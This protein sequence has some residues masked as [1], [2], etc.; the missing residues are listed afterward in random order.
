MVM[1][2]AIQE[3]EIAVI[4]AGPG[5]YVAAIRLA[6]LGKQVVLIDKAGL[7]G[8]C[9][10]VGCIPSK[11]LITASN[12]FGMAN[13]K[14]EMG[15]S[16]G[17]V[18]LDSKKLHEWKKASI[19]QLEK[20]IEGLCAKLG[21]EVVKGTATIEDSET[22]R[23][24]SEH[25]T[26][27][28][29]F[30]QCIINTGTTP[31]EY[32]G[33]E[34][35]N[36]FVWNSDHAMDIEFIPRDLVVIGGGYIGVELASVYAKFGCNV[37][38]V[39]RSERI[40]TQMDSDAA[41]VVQKKMS[42]HGIHLFL[43]SVFKSAHRDKNRVSV[44]IESGG[45]K[46]VIETEKILVA[47]GRVPNTKHIGLENTRVQ[48]NEN[49]FIRVN[50]QCQT[51]DPK[52]WAIG[53]VTGPPLLA[54]RATRMG[55]VC[56]EAIA[57]QPA[58]FDN[59]AIPGVVFSDPELASVGLTE[60]EA[61]EKGIEIIVGK[62]PFHALGRAV[63]TDKTEGFVKVIADRNT[64][65]VLGVVAVGEHVSEFIGE[66]ALAIEMGAQLED[67]AAT[68]HPHPTFSEALMEA[69]EEALGKAIHVTQKKK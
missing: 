16:V 8:I 31:V 66:A 23:V 30:R 37:S 1:G 2:E 61:K 50:A 58:A 5:G 48:L 47:L 36:D 18:S 12:F 69:C 33:L 64:Q 55:K 65:V 54:H 60:K 52:I 43:N 25:G 45:K 27:V 14:N 17:G 35:A 67:I 7:G 49:G 29:K 11:A 24:S 56:A 63:S 40:L 6:Q 62:F 41:L 28:I 19:K 3:T 51:S 38:V 44:T 10:H 57:G 15:I 22:I 21:I 13:R 53:D 68:I 46:S 34:Y 4:G 59:K 32:P 9:L 20:G 42:V 39:Q 26:G